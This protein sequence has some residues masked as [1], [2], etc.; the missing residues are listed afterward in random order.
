MGEGG[1]GAV[2][3]RSGNTVSK[4]P[5]QVFVLCGQ[6]AKLNNDLIKEIVNLV[7]VVALTELGRLEPLIDNIFWRQ[8][9]LVT[10][11]WL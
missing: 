2:A 9:H 5:A 1:N 3:A 4:L 6:A 10:S 11:Y 7:L 8:S